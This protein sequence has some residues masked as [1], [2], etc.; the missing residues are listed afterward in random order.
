MV[1]K[2]NFQGLPL[3]LDRMKKMFDLKEFLLVPT[4]LCLRLMRPFLLP[5]NALK[6]AKISSFANWCKGASDACVLFGF[7]MLVSMAMFIPGFYDLASRFL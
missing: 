3:P 7:L 1:G 2:T 4:W 5:E 6:D